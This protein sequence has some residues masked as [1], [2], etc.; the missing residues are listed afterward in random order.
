[1]AVIV[2]QARMGSQRLPGKVLRPL[3]DQQRPVLA[4]AVRAARLSGVNAKLVLATTRGQ[5]DDAIAA[6]C[7][8]QHQAG[9]D[10]I[11]CIRGDEHDVLGR[12]VLA[13]DSLGV[14]DPVTV[15]R[16]TADC[17]LLDPT[18]IRM[19][20]RAFE[21]SGGELDYLSTVTPRSLPVGLDVEV[22]TAALLRR[23]DGVAEGFDRVHVTSRLYREA[24]WCRVGGVTF[25]PAAHDLRVTLDT[26]EDAAVIE[27]IV[28]ELGDRPPG[29][30][31]V[32]DLLR[33]RPDL[34]ALNASVP[35]KPL[36]AG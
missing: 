22:T 25:S 1:M 4:W 3:G 2:I 23:L 5:R 12:F 10:D 20:V 35:T 28:A 8:D 21:A 9:D 34:A 33:R 17:P 27:G 29:W 15:V 11:V 26:P 16:L 30:R 19:C 31:E 6:W 36:A 32:V 13:L 7:A 14:P 24:G 18:V